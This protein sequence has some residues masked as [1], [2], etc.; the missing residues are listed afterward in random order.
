MLELFYSRRFEKAEQMEVLGEQKGT[1]PRRPDRGNE[2]YGGVTG[3]TCIIGY[4]RS[5]G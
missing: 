3:K 4:V 2:A 1:G 5:G